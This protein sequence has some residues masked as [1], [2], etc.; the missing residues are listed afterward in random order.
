MVTGMAR[1]KQVLKP[2]KFET[3]IVQTPLPWRCFG[4]TRTI[5][6]IFGEKVK[7]E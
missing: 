2:K 6:I 3:V 1:V 7:I 4:C 5:F